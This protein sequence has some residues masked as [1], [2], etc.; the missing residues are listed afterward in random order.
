MCPNSLAEFAAA[1]A[2]KVKTIFC[3]G[4]YL[5]ENTSQAASVEFFCFGRKIMRAADCSPFCRKTSKGSFG[6]LESSLRDHRR[7]PVYGVFA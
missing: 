2:K 1:A 6:R 5:A 7:E 3:R 4:V